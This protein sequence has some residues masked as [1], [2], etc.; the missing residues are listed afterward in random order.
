MW[1]GSEDS[2]VLS[3]LLTISVCDNHI[4][5]SL[6]TPQSQCA[7]NIFTMSA[8]SSAEPHTPSPDMQVDPPAESTSSGTRTKRA[9]A[10]PLTRDEV[11]EI[12]A[13][14]KYAKM[15]HEQIVAATPFTINQVQVACKEKGQRYQ[16]KPDRWSIASTSAGTATDTAGKSNTPAANAAINNGTSTAAFA[17]P[18]PV[19]AAAGAPAVQHPSS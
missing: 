2:R 7:T 11:I 8:S 16:K 6:T 14:R 17:P 10:R 19:A 15:T 1:L 9:R 18:P 13:L 3:P 4:P 12:R 5:T